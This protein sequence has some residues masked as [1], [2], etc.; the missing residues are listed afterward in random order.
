MDSYSFISIML[1]PEQYST[2]ALLVRQR[3]HEYHKS[4]DI[5]TFLHHHTNKHNLLVHMCYNTSL[6]VYD[7]GRI[8]QSIVFSLIDIS[9]PL[10][11]LRHTYLVDHHY[12]NI[13]VTSLLL[14]N[15]NI[16]APP[17]ISNVNNTIPPQLIPR[18]CQHNDNT[19]N[20]QYLVMISAT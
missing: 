2:I 3:Y 17:I 8:L 19:Y 14:H 15:Y 11:V 10:S 16:T 20:N 12:Y 1:Q 9:T 4:Y 7:I 5:L 18:P 6:F 13:T